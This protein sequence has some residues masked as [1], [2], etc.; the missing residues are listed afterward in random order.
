MNC[1][2]RKNL[3]IILGILAV[4]FVIVKVANLNVTAFLPFLALLACPLMCVAMAFFMK[5]GHN[6]SDDH[7]HKKDKDCC[8]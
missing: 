6:K 8:S 4:G 5:E 1:C 7:A 2:S 3:F